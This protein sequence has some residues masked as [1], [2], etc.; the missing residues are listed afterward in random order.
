MT[1]LKEMIPDE[2]VGVEDFYYKTHKLMTIADFM[3]AMTCL[4]MIRAIDITSE[5]VIYKIC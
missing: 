1:M 2:G 4:Y 3:D 5:N